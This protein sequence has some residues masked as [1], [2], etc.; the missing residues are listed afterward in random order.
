M[1]DS[2]HQSILTGPLNTP[3]LPTQGGDPASMSGQELQ[4]VVNSRMLAS[5]STDHPFVPQNVS[6]ISANQPPRPKVLLSRV[7]SL[8]NPSGVSSSSSS[9]GEVTVWPNLL[10]AVCSNSN[11]TKLVCESNSA[12]FNPL[13][14]QIKS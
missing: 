13:N 1:G 6:G 9:G 14:P 7:H 5:E 10:T 8:L 3:P 11:T 2:I 12:L 4:Q